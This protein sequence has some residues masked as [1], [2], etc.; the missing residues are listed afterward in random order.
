MREEDLTDPERRLWQAFATG[1]KVD[2]R[3][4]TADGAGAEGD[5]SGWG[6]E[7]TV[8]ASVIRA[9]LL[10][11]VEPRAGETPVVHLVGA[12]I[13]GRLDLVFCEARCVLRLEECRFEQAPQLYG[14]R[15]H[16]TGFARSHL[17]GLGANSITVG[18]HL[19]LMHTRISGALRL[20]NARIDGSLLLQG[21]LLAH[22]GAVV[23]DGSWLET[24][25]GIVCHSGFR[26]E[27]EMRLSA[28]RV[29]EGLHL[30]G[31][32][33]QHPGGDALYAPGIHIGSDAAFSDGFH[34]DGAIDLTGATT[35]GRVSF[36]TATVG[37]T[38]ARGSGPRGADA[39]EADCRGV[40]YRHLQAAE[41]DLSAARL[42]GTVDLQH[43]QVGVLHLP[44]E[45][46][47]C[48]L[49]LD[50]LEYRSLRPQL[51]AGARLPLIARDPDGYRPQP[52]QQLA[53]VYQSLGHDHDARAVLLAK[54]RHRRSTL[55]L[56][57]RAWGQLLD[58]TVGYGYR[59]WLAGLW[60][61]AL[62]LLGTAVFSA[63]E[64]TPVKQGEGAPFQPL[65]YTLDLLVPIGALGQRNAWYWTTDPQQFLAYALIAVGWLL[66][67]AVVAGVSRVLNRN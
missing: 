44:V 27:G 45:D 38:G 67:T 53:A 40:T 60:L 57:G 36:H 65:V 43:T 55:R 61:T 7:R 9:L 6:P 26:A 49:H 1:T 58:A 63:A 8:R 51:P 4:R 18:G 20:T 22:P 35:G 12:R 11:S 54:Q 42:H 32:R 17:P 10:G 59:P 21:A 25:G 16:V 41:L 37:G 31:A 50:G 46:F 39:R 64:P 2:L 24:G 15:L 34:A 66:T 33:L 13:A 3:D 23:L 14:A 28:A 56:A 30:Q 5:E 52:Y 19:D 47:T 48:P 62:T 29:G